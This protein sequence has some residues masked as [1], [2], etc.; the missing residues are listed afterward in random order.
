MLEI[1]VESVD[2]YYY[3]STLLEE[4]EPEVSEEPFV[5]PPGLAIPPD[6]ELVSNNGGKMSISS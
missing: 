2:V 1:K 3:L 5:A 4:L 6:V